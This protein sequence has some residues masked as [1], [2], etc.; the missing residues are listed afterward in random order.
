MVDPFCRPFATSCVARFISYLSLLSCAATVPAALIKCLFLSYIIFYHLFHQTAFIMTNDTC[1]I[2]SL[3]FI[4]LFIFFS[5]F[6]SES[7]LKRD[8][9]LNHFGMLYTIFGVFLGIL[10]YHVKMENISLAQIAKFSLR[11]C[12][13]TL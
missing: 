8:F 2:F 6:F 1:V 7:N 5:F 4:Y 10:R 11:F 3:F 9:H 13:F 12:S